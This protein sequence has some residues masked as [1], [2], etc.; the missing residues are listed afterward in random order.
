VDSPISMKQERR[1][2]W[3]MIVMRCGARSQTKVRGWEDR[4]CLVDVVILCGDA[5][6]F[7]RLPCL[8]YFLVVVS[9]VARSD[10]IYHTRLTYVLIVE[11]NEGS[12]NDKQPRR[13]WLFSS[14]LKSSLHDCSYSSYPHLRQ[15]VCPS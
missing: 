3:G 8:T 13:L 2:W 4:K 6:R 12:S 10:H 15:P 5:M 7:P 14:Q 1:L 9:A 11:L